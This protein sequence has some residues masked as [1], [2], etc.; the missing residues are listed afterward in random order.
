M[1]WKFKGGGFYN[2][3]PA[4]DL[5]DAEFE[6]LS[7]AGQQVVKRNQF[8]ERADVIDPPLKRRPTRYKRVLLVCPT[9][10][11]EPETIDRIHSQ[12]WAGAIDF[13]FTRDNPFKEGY[14]NIELNMNK[15]RD[16]FLNGNYDAMFVVESD[17]LP[18]Y[19]ALERLANVDAD[20][21]GGLYV[22]R[23]WAGATNAMVYDPSSP[24]NLSATPLHQFKDVDLL[25]TNG[26]SCGCVLIRREVL[27]EI[28]FHAEL[29]L[30]PDSPFMRDCNSAGFV[31]VCD[32]TVICGHK[33]E[34]GQV[35]YPEI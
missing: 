13:Y 15:A 3:V 5:T 28:S 16:V 22:M 32:A 10:R 6:A 2:D 11:L 25:R 17:M 1:G 21:A 20:I 18:P 33:T 7:Y 19:D 27:K 29:P 31:T 9:Y 4:R 26:V 35:L 12:K 24:L 30:P 14:L 23:Q 34:N 8:Y